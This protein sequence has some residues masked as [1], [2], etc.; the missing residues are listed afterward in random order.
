MR[1]RPLLVADAPRVSSAGETTPSRIA[2]FVP[3]D[4][5]R[6][7][8]PGAVPISTSRCSSEVASD[9]GRA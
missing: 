5:Y 7:L 8:P 3:Q 6:P 9:R 4:P 1:R 2:P